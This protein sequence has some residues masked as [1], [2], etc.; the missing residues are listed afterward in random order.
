[1]EKC[2]LANCEVSGHF[3][4][5]NST[6]PHKPLM[7]LWSPGR[8]PTFMCGLMSGLVVWSYTT[9]CPNWGHTT[10]ILPQS[11]KEQAD[12]SD[13]KL[14]YMKLTLVSLQNHHC[15]H[16]YHFVSG[17]EITVRRPEVTSSPAQSKLGVCS[18]FKMDHTYIN[19]LLSRLL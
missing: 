18:Y 1:M 3:A 13:R 17:E 8:Q 5:L 19:I 16:K 15:K 4:R 14:R 11:T 2:S 7:I 6:Y 9:E 12:L 10:L